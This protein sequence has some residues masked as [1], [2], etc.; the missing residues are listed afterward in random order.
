MQLDDVKSFSGL[1]LYLQGFLSWDDGPGYDCGGVIV[2]FA[3]LL[4]NLREHRHVSLD[5]IG[6]YL[7]DEQREFLQALAKRAHDR[8]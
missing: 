6:G 7:N 1:E 3:A 5:S 2:L 4:E 8:N